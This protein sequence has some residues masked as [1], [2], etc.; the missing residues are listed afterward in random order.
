MADSKDT[1]YL[2]VDEEITSIVN[3][4][5]GSPKKIVALVLPK[6]A[7]VF[8]SVVNMKLL[9]RTA[10]QNDKR[11]VLITSEAALMP[12]AGVAGVYVA[13]NLNSKPFIPPSPKISEPASGD[14]EDVQIDPQTPIGEVADP[15]ESIE[16]DNSAPKPAMASGKPKKSKKSKGSKFKV[17][18][19]DSFRKKLFL[20]ILLG[21]LIVAGLIW[22]IL[23]SPKA[24]VTLKTESS[25]IPTSFDFTA[26]ET[27]SEVN[28]EQQI[29]PAAKKEQKNDESEKSSAT[30]QKDK[31]AKAGGVVKIST[32]DFSICSPSA[33]PIVVPAGTGMSSGN[34]TYITQNSATLGRQGPSCTLEA[35][36]N[37][38]AQNNG[39]EYN[40]G[41]QSYSV[42]G[43]SNLSASGSKMTGGSSKIVKVITD[44]DVEAAKQRIEAKKDE[45]K[46]ELEDDLKRDGYI[47][48]S[49]TFSDNSP[50]YKVS[51]GVGTEGEEVTVS[52]EIT[53][54]MIGV[55]EDDLKKLID[56]QVKDQ[57]NSDKQSI[58]S[59]GLAQAIYKVNESE[60]DRTTINI[61]TTVSVGP[62]LDQEELKAEIVGKKPQEAEE[63]LKGRSGVIEARVEIKP[64][65]SSK[66]PKKT[67]RIIFVIEDAN[68]NEIDTSNQAP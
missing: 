8:Q 18:N 68:G 3:K 31:G 65:W 49:E 14:D 15:E 45:V 40:V 30:G 23:L 2:D 10:D 16:I 21:I 11:V 13:S 9:K 28:A 61:Q 59:Q 67:S 32:S 52:A 47:A 5:Q 42:S 63:I 7:S 20:G 54:S 37:V 36:V 58:L 43:F 33:D 60:G 46:K 51:P 35:N 29:V 64:G 12:L 57:V 44:Q 53:Y 22:F 4:V 50:K 17:P 27:A 26:D 25:E 34:Q 55:K 19:F 66:V 1:I 24:T 39:E 41:S 48:L 38:L 6:R 56:E 62:D